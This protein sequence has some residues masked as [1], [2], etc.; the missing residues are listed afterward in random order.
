M[1]FVLVVLYFLMDIFI[2][3]VQFKYSQS[4]EETKEKKQTTEQILNERHWTYL[5]LT[6]F[7]D[8]RVY[9]QRR[10]QNIADNAKLATAKAVTEQ[11]KFQK[12][13]QMNMKGGGDNDESK[14]SNDNASVSM[15]HKSHKSENE[16]S[17]SNSDASSSSSGSSNSGSSS[18]S[19]SSSSSKNSSESDGEEGKDKGKSTGEKNSTAD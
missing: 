7:H 19:G 11:K 16:S 12:N 1:V 6:Y 17:S 9:C 10:Q 4:Y 3:L 18:G 2:A 14:M 13:I 8:A 5:L 15:S